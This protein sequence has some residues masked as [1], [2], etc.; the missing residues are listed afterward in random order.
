MARYVTLRAER[1]DTILIRATCEP[2]ATG[3]SVRC[4]ASSLMISWVI[5]VAISAGFEG[6]KERSPVHGRKG[7]RKLGGVGRRGR[8]Y[9]KA[10]EQRMPL[11]NNDRVWRR[12]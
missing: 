2:T 1:T 4:E 8:S 9:R 7:E 10:V 11:G 5:F 3:A 6:G 12:Q